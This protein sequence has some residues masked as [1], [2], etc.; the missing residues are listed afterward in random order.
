MSSR[1]GRLRHDPGIRC[2]AWGEVQRS[3]WEGGVIG[4][5]WRVIVGNFTTCPHDWELLDDR[6]IFINEKLAGHSYLYR[7]KKCCDTKS[8]GL[9]R[10]Q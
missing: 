8:A 2:G 6:D 5:L 3:D 4:W 9:G 1:L 10:W 7:C